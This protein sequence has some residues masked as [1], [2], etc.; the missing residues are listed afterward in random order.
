[1]KKDVE[2]MTPNDLYPE[3]I[4]YR[5]EYINLLNYALEGAVSR[6]EAGQDVEEDIV[7]IKEMIKNEKL[8][9]EL[10]KGRFKK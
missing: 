6:R 9:T 8:V 7:E 1:M 3:T 10:M 2:N 4:T 5:L